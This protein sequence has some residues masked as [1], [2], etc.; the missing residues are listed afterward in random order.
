MDFLFGNVINPLKH[1]KEK[2]ERK[3][4][5]RA[6]KERS[7]RRSKRHFIFEEIKAIIFVGGS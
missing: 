2:K 6:G 5:R 4:N 3:N 7:H 1:T